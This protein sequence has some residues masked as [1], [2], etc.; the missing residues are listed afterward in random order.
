MALC[1]TATYGAIHILKTN[2]QI[3]TIIT[4]LD[5]DSAG[6][7]GNYRLKEEIL[8]LGAYTVS[9][10]QPRFKDWNE[11]LKSEH[12]IKPLPGTEHPGLVRM[13]TLC[14]ELAIVF[15]G[16]RCPKYPLDELKEQYQKLR[17]L[18]MKRPRDIIMQS[19]EM[20]GI[21][22]LLGQKQFAS[23]EKSYTVQ[24][25][26]KILFRLYA[27]HHDKIGYKARIAEI[28]ERL[29]EI[30]QA[31]QK[32][33]ILSESA[34]MEQIKNTLSLAV[35][36]LRLE[37]YVEREQMEMQRRESSCQTESSPMAMQQ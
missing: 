28:G 34:Q 12:G 3:D 8:R 7:E 4:C 27:P 25:Y 17:Q 23:L 33:E 5:H 11:G 6:I 24:Q 13:K 35:D 31:F 10:E 21:A 29:E 20:A 26:E 9:A 22:F 30:G 18:S 32:N 19:S 15:T 1:S 37:T 36:C 2:P 14:Q 16:D